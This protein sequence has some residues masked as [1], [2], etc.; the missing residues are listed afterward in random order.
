MY[1]IVVGLHS[2]SGRHIY[3]VNIDVACT[4]LSYMLG[5]SMM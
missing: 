5:K 4:W 1:L 3:C 2:C